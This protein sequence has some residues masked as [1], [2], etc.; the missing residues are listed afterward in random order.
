[1]SF[2]SSPNDKISDEITYLDA[3]EFISK[4]YKDWE[5]VLDVKR[6]V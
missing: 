2:S 6:F 1:M 4:G 3:V 5:F